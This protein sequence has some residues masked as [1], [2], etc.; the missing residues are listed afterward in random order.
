MGKRIIA[1]AVVLSCT[2]WAQTPSWQRRAPETG[3]LEL[4]HAL[5]VS[6]LP[7]AETL[8]QGDLEFEVSHR[9]IP[10]IDSGADAFYGFDGPA[11]I[12]LALDYAVTDRL[13]ITVGRTNVQDN[14]ELQIKYKA[15]QFRH[16]RFPVLVSLRG[17]SAYNSEIFAPVKSSVRRWQFYG[18]LIANTLVGEKLGIGV[19]PSYLYNS[20]IFC[21]DP[22]YSFT[23]GS[24]VQYYASPHWSVFAEWNP[25][26]SG[27]RKTYDSF[28]LGLELE[29]GGHF[30][31]I[32][33]TNNDKLNSSLFLAGADRDFWAGDM[34]FG[35]MITRLIKL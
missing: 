23:F 13:L 33:L 19:V 12:R 3:P 18:Q 16:D 32:I 29:T 10:T 14:L 20:H 15:L 25:T 4:F 30:F 7:T 22:Q 6:M 35:F 28:S 24:Y 11:N 8:Q 1:I 27:W 2:V 34:R 26:V 5:H 17:G 21:C 9:F 31:K